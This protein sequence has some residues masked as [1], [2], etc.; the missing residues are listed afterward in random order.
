M[1]NQFES[2]LERLLY[3][4]IF[5]SLRETGGLKFEFQSNI[6][7]DVRNVLVSAHCTATLII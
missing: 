2:N 3:I 4:D 5:C 7:N 6:F 1:D